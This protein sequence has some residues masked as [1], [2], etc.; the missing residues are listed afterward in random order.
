VA[1]R[2][3]HEISDLAFTVLPPRAFYPVHW[4]KIG[5]LFVAPKDRKDKRWVKA[6]E[7]NIKG[8]SFGIHL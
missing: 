8:E 2:L 5:G 1:A 7:E 6:K 4:S 3:R